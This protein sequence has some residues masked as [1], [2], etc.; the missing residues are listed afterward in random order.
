M[1]PRSRIDAEALPL[2]LTP[3]TVFVTGKGGVGKSTVAAALAQAWCAAGARTLLVEI[4]GQASAAAL[5]SPKRVGYQPVPLA[6]HLSALRI[7]LND[8]LREYARLR[9]KVKLVADR[10]VGNAVIDQ[11][12]QAAPGFRELLVLGKIWALAK[13]VDD[14]GRPRWD[15]IVV[16]SPA[17]GHGLGLLGMAG[18]IARMFPVGPVS[19]EARAVDRFVKDAERVGVVLVA[20]AEE[21]PVT[22]TLELQEQLAERGVSVCATVLNG[23]LVDRFTEDEAQLA[24]RLAGDSSL[25]ASIRHALETVLWERIRCGDQAS[26]RTR[27]ESGLGDGTFGLLPYMYAPHLE[28]E[29]LTSMARWL[30]IGGQSVLRQQLAGAADGPAAAAAVH[31]SATEDS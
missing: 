6:E 30:T 28:R 18:V 24:S 31:A 7:T 4:E 22:E 23:L 27:L 2:G 20:L 10:L 19:A 5:L 25:D 1:P 29:H 14:R 11:F 8:A 3:R 15:A 13:E 26:E 16:D 9:V 21:L 17:T 12:A